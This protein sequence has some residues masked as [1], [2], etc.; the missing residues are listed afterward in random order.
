VIIS[1]VPTY[2]TYF[3][4]FATNVNAYWRRHSSTFTWKSDRSHSHSGPSGDGKE[5]S[6]SKRSSKSGSQGTT[7]TTATTTTTGSGGSR[8]ERDG[9]VPEMGVSSFNEFV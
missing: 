1:C 2:G 9:M 3:H 7:H 4:T 6:H 8:K 5:N